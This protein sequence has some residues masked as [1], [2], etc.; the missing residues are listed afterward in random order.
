M[1][2]NT[3][4]Y[5]NPHLCVSISVRMLLD[6]AASQVSNTPLGFG[7]ELIEAGV[8]TL[9]Q[10]STVIHTQKMRMCDDEREQGC[11]REGLWFL[12]SQL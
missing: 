1:V 5:V 10:G 6:K 2:C 4:S 9:K 11:K 3:V 8:E 7:R 12:H